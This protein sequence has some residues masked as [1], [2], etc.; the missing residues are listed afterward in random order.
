M[1]TPTDIAKYF[2]VDDKNDSGLAQDL[3]NSGAIQSGIL[4]SPSDQIS[5][6]VRVLHILVH[7]V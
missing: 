4:S 1:T 3:I 7:P 5:P 2:L 6:E